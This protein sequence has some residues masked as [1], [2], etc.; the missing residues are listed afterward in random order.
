M[1]KPGITNPAVRKRTRLESFFRKA[2]KE[3]IKDRLDLNG[4]KIFMKLAGNFAT[5]RLKTKVLST[6]LTKRDSEYIVVVI[7][8]FG[9]FTVVEEVKTV[10]GKTSKV[11][12]AKPKAKGK[13]RDDKGGKK[14][15]MGKGGKGMMMG[16]KSM[17]FSGKDKD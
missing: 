11:S 14:G 4:M 3:G 16:G 15:K 5:E 12:K 9:E 17:A 7:D 1:S 8:E 2:L 13:D 10:A 6:S